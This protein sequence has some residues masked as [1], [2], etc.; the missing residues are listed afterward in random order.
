MKNILRCVVRKYS[1]Q[2]ALDC[3][4]KEWN[5]NYTETDVVHWKHI[6]QED[7]LK[8]LEELNE[9]SNSNNPTT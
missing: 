5:T 1:L 2:N 3:L 8:H 6:T 7:A 4:N 9:G